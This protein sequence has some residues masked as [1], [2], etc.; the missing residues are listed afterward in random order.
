MNTSTTTAATAPAPAPAFDPSTVTVGTRVWLDDL[1]FPASRRWIEAAVVEV[2]PTAW[3]VDC[4]GYS[5]MFPR[6]FDFPAF[7]EGVRTVSQPGRRD[8]VGY[9]SAAAVELARQDYAASGREAR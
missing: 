1:N 8:L 9:F 7:D 6:G 3:A 4:E 5:A 2:T